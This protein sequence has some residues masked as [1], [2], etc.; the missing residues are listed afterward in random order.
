[1]AK[2]EDIKNVAND[3]CKG[4]EAISTGG[5]ATATKAVTWYGK[6]LEDGGHW[7]SQAIDDTGNAGKDA[8]NWTA[9]ATEDALNWVGGIFGATGNQGYGYT[10]N[11]ALEKLRRS[12]N[13]G[14]GI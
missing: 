4:V 11:Q 7:T 10:G 1:M 13:I 5:C 12:T 14:A 2:T 9:D 3:S 8:W 6:A